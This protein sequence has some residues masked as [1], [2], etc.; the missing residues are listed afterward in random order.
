MDIQSVFLFSLGVFVSLFIFSLLVAG[1]ISLIR[2][3]AKGG[4]K[5]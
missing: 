2:L 1:L 3:L 4:R 5:G